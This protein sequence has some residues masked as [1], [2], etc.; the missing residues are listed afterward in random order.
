MSSYESMNNIFMLNFAR[1]LFPL[2][3]EY[4]L[5]FSPGKLALFDYWYNEIETC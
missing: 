3:Q 2:F 1:G 5:L 4:I